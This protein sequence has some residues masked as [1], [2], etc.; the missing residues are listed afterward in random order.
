MQDLIEVG[1]LADDYAETKVAKRLR[2]RVNSMISGVDTLVARLEVE[3]RNIKEEISDPA[4]PESAEKKEYAFS[5][6]S[7]NN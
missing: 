7:T 6:E 3:R 2:A 4:L 5:G 1:S